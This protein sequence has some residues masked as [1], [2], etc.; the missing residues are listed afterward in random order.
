MVTLSRHRRRLIGRLVLAG[1]LAIVFSI[2]LFENRAWLI[3]RLAP[4]AG[5]AAPGQAPAADAPETYGRVP[6]RH[7]DEPIAAARVAAA[8]RS[9]P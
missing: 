4:D 1:V 6:R 8:P 9:S 3:P 5:P 7:P 2:G